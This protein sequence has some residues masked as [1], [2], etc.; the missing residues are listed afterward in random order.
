MPY[1]VS[2]INKNSYG[3]NPRN[4]YSVGDFLYLIADNDA[5]GTELWQVNQSTGVA[6]VVEVNP[7]SAGSNPNN[8][9]VAGNTL[10]FTASNPTS[11]N[12]LWKIV[13]GGTPTVVDLY[14][15]SGS[16]S[17]TDFV[18][19]VGTIYFIASG[20]NGT[21]FTGREIWRID[22][23][24][25]TATV[26]ELASGSGSISPDNLTNVNG[27]L[28]FTASN[29][30]TTN[31]GVELYK[32]DGNTPVLLKDIYV[33]TNGSS[34]SNL[35]YANGKL[36]FT[37]ENFTEGTELW[38]TDGT[39]A[40][41]KLTSDINTN[42]YSSNPTSFISVGTTL[43]FIANNDVSGYE[44]W[45]ADAAGNVSIVELAAG[46]GGI[47]P[48]SGSANISNLTNVNGTLYFQAY[49]PTDGY[50]LWKIDT[51]GTLSQISLYAG[52]NG[53]YVE[54]G[55]SSPN[56]LIN[57]GG[58]LYFTASGYDGV[59]SS[60]L[61]GNELWRIDPT[62]GNP[63]VITIAAGSGSSSPSNLTSIGGI[64]YFQASTPA[65]GRELWKVNPDDNLP[66]L[67]S[68]LYAGGNSSNPTAV[69]SAGGNIYFVAN[70]GLNGNELFRITGNTAPE[71]LDIRT[72]PAIAA[73]SSPTG[74]IDVGGILYFLADNGTNGQELWKANSTGAPIP[75]EI[76]TGASGANVNYLTNVG[77][78][79]YFSAS[80]DNNGYE[81][82]KIGTDGNPARIDIGT[83]GS[84]PDNLTNVNGTLYFRSTEAYDGTTFV[85]Y[86][87]L[88][89]IDSTGI[90]TLIQV[91]S[92]ATYPYV[93]NITLVGSKLFFSAND[94]TNGYELWKV[95]STGGAELVKDIR[96]GSNSSSPGN[97]FAIGE[98]LYFTAN[99]GVSGNELWKSDGTAT[100][101]VLAKDI[102]GRT[103]PSNPTSFIT[104]GNTLYFLADNGIDGQELW[105]VDPSTGLPVQLEINIGNESALGGGEG[106][107]GFGASAQLE[108][109]GDNQPSYINYLT[110]VN[111]TLYFSA[112]DGTNGTELWK[113][114]TDGNPTR[115]DIGTNG[116]SPDNLT[117]V[118]GTLYFRSNEAYSGTNF[119]GYGQLWKIDSTTGTP[120]LIQVGSDANYPYV[121][122][123]TLVGS[124]LFFSAN[125]GTNGYELWKVGSTGAE[126]VK[127][128]RTG[129]NSSSPANFFDVNGTLYFTANDGVKG[130]E[131]WKSDGTAA[132]TVLAKD[133]N[134]RTLP[135][136][137]TNLINVGNTLYFLAD[138]GIDGRELWKVDPTTGLPVQL[139]I[140]SGANG[141]NVN[142]LT[143]VNGTLYFSAND[144]NNGTELWK[145]GT[146][147][148]PARIDIGNG[149]SS[150]DNL[151]NVNG[152]LYFRSTEA[153]SGTDFVGYGQLWK[154]DSTTGA[155]SII[156]VGSEVTYP[157][158]DNIT[159]VGS[160][161]Y[162]SANDGTNGNELWKVNSTGAELVKDIR[163]GS[164]SSSPDNFFDVNGTLYFTANDGVNGNELWKSD[165]TATGTVMLEI[166]TGSTGTSI[167]NM[168]SVAG[169]LYFTAQN[170][171]NGQE[172]W[173]INAAGN[174]E[175][176]DNINVGTGSSSPSNL[177]NVNGTLYF[178]AYNP[179][180]GFELWKVVG[181]SGTPTLIN[182]YNGGGSSSPSN[183]LNING[184]LYFTASG[185]NGTTSTG[186]ELWKIDPNGTLSTIEIVAGGTGG[187]PTNLTN[188]NGNLYFTAYYNGTI[189]TGLELYRL[190]PVTGTPV[191]LKDIYVGS[192]G[193]DPGSL[194]YSNGKLYFSAD[195]FTEGREL[196]AYDIISITT[197]GNV[198]KTG[199]EDQSIAFAASDFASVFNSSNGGT[200]ASIRVVALPSNGTL[201]LNNVNVAANQEILAANLGSL[202]F[203][204]NANFNGNA[205]FTWNGSD[206]TTYATSPATVSM[207][208]AAVNDAPELV[209]A[210]PNVNLTAN[211]IANFSISG[212][213]FRDVDLDNL[214]Y[215]ATLAD[216]SALPS[217][218]TFNGTSF[219][220]TPPI[221]SIGQNIEVKVTATDASSATAT[222]NFFLNILS[223]APNYI[224]VGNSGSGT[225]AENSANDAQV[226]V[227]T[228]A[229]PSTND[230]FTY[231]LLN[232][233]GGRFKVDG[234]RLLV[235]DTSLLDYETNTSHTI[236]VRT[237]DGTGLTYERDIT[238]F[239]SNVNDAN[240]G[241]L[242]FTAPT[243][244][245][246]ENGTTV[247]AVTVQ[248]TNG[249]EGFVRANIVLTN[250]T[251]TYPTD[252]SVVS[253]PVDFA[254][255]ETSKTVTIPIV[256]DTLT[257]M[258]ET[259]NLTL[260]SP[261]GGAT[262]GT[263]TTAVL[264]VV[265]D[266]EFVAGIL[267]FASNSYTVNENGTP[268]VTILRT[269]G[270]NGT[271]SVNILPTDGTA[272]APGDYTTTPISVSFA[273][274]ETSKTVALTGLINDD[275]S[276]EQTENLTLTLST[277]MG[278]A[279]LGTQQTAT[280]N[281][282]DN[283]A[284]PGVVQFSSAT[285]SVDEAGTPV[286][287]ITLNRTGGS[288][289]AV[290]VRVDL[291]NGT[292]TSSDYNSNPITVSFAN[293]ETSKT[294]TIPIVNDTL[295]E[296]D[297]TVTLTLT[298]PQGGAT[299]GTQTTSVLTI[300]ANDP[301][302]PGTLAFASNS[303]S[304]NENGIP[305]VTV[306]RTGGSSGMV[307]VNIVP[308]DGTA[309]TP[310]DYNSTPISVSFAD[311]EI[312]KTVD[313]TGLVTDDALYELAENLTLTLATPMG[314][315][316][317]GTQQTAT[318]NIV[319][320]DAVPGVIQLSSATYS[321]N[322]DGTP[323]T[324]IIT[325]NRTGGSDG[326]VS[327]R[328]DLSNGTA[329]SSDY[330][331]SPI[332]VNF[333]NGE[334]S[335]TVTIPITND[336]AIESTET[337]NLTLTNPTGG[338]AIDP[339]KN[340]A[341]VSIIDDD[342]QIGFGGASY[343]VNE[344]GT[345]I[346][347][348]TVTRSGRTTGSVSATLSFTDGTAKGCVC[349][350]SSV[351]NDFFNGTFAINFADGET[352]KVIPVQLA[353]LG[354][355]NALRI[356]DDARVEGDEYFSINL[357]SPTG[358]ATIGSQ[359][360]ATVT[361]VDN[362]T[363]PVLSV[364]FDRNSI[365]ENAGT[366][367]AT[368]TVTRSMAT[369][370]PLVVSLSSDDPTEATVPQ[371]VTIAAGQ[372][373]T[374]FSI[375]AI[376]DLLLDGT[377][378]VTIAATPINPGTTDPLLAGKGTGSIQVTD[379]E[380]PGLFLKIDRQTIAETG[381]AIATIT[382]NTDPTSD[383]VVNL[384]SNDPTE[385]TVPQQVT[386]LAG[387]ATAT[388][389]I[390]GVNDGIND[391]PQSVI[392][393][394][395]APGLTAVTE[396]LKVTDSNVANLTIT[397]LSGT[398]PTYTTKQSQF[399]YTV[400]NS[401]ITTATGTWK[402]RVYL[403]TDNKLDSSDL[404]LNE[405]SLGTATT[406]AQLLPNAA[407]TQTVSYVAPR[408]AGQYYLIATTDVG[409]TIDEG[410]T[411][412]EGDNTSISAVK[413]TPAYR[414]AVSTDT[415][416]AVVGT[417]VIMRGQALSNIDNS[418]VA[419][420]FVKIQIE[421]KGSTREV[422]AFTDGSGNFVAKFNPLPNEAG[423]Y[424]IK[425]YFPGNVGEDL[426]AEDQFALLGMR[427]EQNDQSLSTVSQKIV[428]GK[429]FSGSVKLQNLADL[430]LSGLTA[431]VV[432]APSNWTVTVTPEKSGLAGNEEI[433][434]NYQITVPDRS[435]LGDVFQLQLQTQEGVVAT[436]PV[437]VNVELILPRLVAD[438]STIQSSMLRGGQNVVEFTVTNQGGAASGKL[439]VVLPDAPWLKLASPVAIPSLAPGESTKVSLL[440][441]AAPDLPLSVYN[442]NLAIN[443][444]ESSLS[445]PF[446]FRSISEA[447]G[448]LKL[449]VV[450]E[451]TFFGD[452]ANVANANIT[453]V[454]AL[455]GTV[456]F[457]G[458][459]ADGLISLTDLNEGYYTLN[460]SADSHDT[461]QQNV[462]VSAGKTESVEAFLSR[463]TVKYTWIV[464]PTEIKDK[465]TISVQ[466][467]FETDVPIPVVT[468][469]PPLIDLANL[470]VIGQV[471]QVDMVVTNHGLIKANDIKLNFGE[472]PFYKIEPLVNN[473]DG[474]AA[475]SSLTVPVRITRIADLNTIGTTSI[476]TTSGELITQAPPS[477]PCSLSGSIGWSYPCGG[478]DINKGSS[479]GFN[480]VAGNCSGTGPGSLN[481]GVVGILGGGGPVGGGPGGGGSVSSY[482]PII[483][484]FDPCCL[485]L[486]YEKDFSDFFKPFVEKAQ[487]TVNIY[488]AAQTGKLAEVKLKVKAKAR[489]ETCCPFD[490]GY[491]ATAEATGELIVG[492]KINIG[493]GDEKKGEDGKPELD[494]LGN[495][496][497]KGYEVPKEL[498]GDSGFKSIKASG[499]LFVGITATP[500]I[501]ISGTV[502]KKCKENFGFEIS[503]KIGAT[504]AAGI[505]GKI[506]VEAELANGEKPKVAVVDAQG[507]LFG[508][509][510]YTFKYSTAGGFSDCVTS[511]GLYLAAYASAFGAT[512]SAFDNPSTPEVETKKYLLDPIACDTP[513]KTSFLDTASSG[514]KF[515]AESLGLPANVSLESYFQAQ[516]E[517]L[518]GVPSLEEKLKADYAARFGTESLN[519]ALI[520]PQAAT[521]SVCAKVKIQI[522]QSAVMTRSAFL[523]S[524]EIENSNATE[525]TNLSV[526]L[527][528][529][530]SKGNLVNTLF[531]ITPA[532]LNN[533]TAVDGTGMLSGE[534]P[535][536]AAKEGIG[537]A[538]WTFIPT[539]LA[540]PEVPEQYSIG[541]TLSY[542]EN[543]KQVTVPLL[544]T[545]VTVYPQAELY[546]NYFQSRNVYGD[547]PFTIDIEP[548]VP[549]D[550][551]VL[552]EN[553]GKGDAKD[554]QITSAQP[555][556]IENEKGLLI[557]FQII[558]SE[559]NGKGVTPSLEANF[560]DIKAGKTA[561]ADWLLK[562]SLQGKFIDYK[563]TFEHV[564]S[565][566]IAELSLIKDVK[567]HELIRKVQVDK[568]TDDG[569]ADFLVN[570]TLDDKFTPDTLYFSQGG[571][572][573][574]NAASGATADGAAATGDLEV[575]ISA[576]TAAG[577]NYIELADP[578][579]A[580]FDIQKIQRA[581]GSEV[582]L[583]NVWTTD[584]TFPGKGRPTYENILH[585]LDNSSAAG[586]TTYTITYKAAGPTVTDIVDVSPDP[587]A[588]AVS[589]IT[590]EF[591]EAIDSSTLD[592][593][594]LSLSL[595]GGTNLIDSTVAVVAVSPTSYQIT[596]LNS[597]TATDGNYALTVNA[598]GIKDIA[599]KSGA[600]A[601]TESWQKIATGVN[602]ITGPAVL[603]VVNLAT[604]L[605]NQTVS[606]L[607]V[608]FSEA[609]DLS[610]LTSADLSLTLNG[611]ANLITNN[612][613][614][615]SVSDKVYRIGGL[616]AL[617]A[618]EGTYTFTVNG[619]GIKDLAGNSGT[620]SQSESWTMD[621]TAP[622]A[623]SNLLVAGLAH[624]A[625][626]Q[627]I[628]TAAPTISGQ[629]AESGLQVSFYDK[630]ANR[631]LS[632]ATVSDTSFTGAVNLPGAGANEVELQ[633]Q[634]AAG[635]IKKTSLELFA[636]LA[637]P[638]VVKLSNLPETQSYSPVTYVDV[639][640]SEAIKASTFT[641][642]DLVLTRDGQDVTLPNTVSIAAISDTVYRVSG[643][644]NS[645]T[646]IGNY[647]FRV[648]ATGIQDL[649]G[650]SA[651]LPKTANFSIIAL[652]TPGF[653]LT[654]TEGNTS[655][656]EGGTTD[657]YSL[658]LK[659]Q[660]TADVTIDLAV[661]TQLTTDKTTL[662]FTPSNWNTAQTVTVTAVNDT[663]PEVTQTV[664]ITHTVTSTDPN[665]SLQT[666]PNLS[667]NITDNDAEIRGLK[668]NDVNGNGIK[669]TTETGLKDWSI[670]LDT[671]TNGQLDAGEI[672]TTT[673]N[674][675]NYS[676]TNL[677]PG[678]YTVA[679]QLQPG[680]KQT[681]PG[682]S[683]TTTAS[684]I[685]LINPSSPIV[686]S[687]TFSTTSSTNLVSLNKLWT[688]PRFTN[689]KGK[690]YSTVIIDT[691]ADLNSPY[692]GADANNDGIAD[693]IVYQYDF[694]DND[695]DASDKNNHGSHVA[696]IASAVA[697]EANLIILKVFKDSGTGSFSNLEKALQWV[698]ANSE[699]YN[700]ASVNLSLGD[701]QDWN[702][703]LSR[704]GIGDELAAIAEQNVLISAAAGNG[705]YTYN[706]AVGLAYPAIDPSVISVGAVWADN[707][708]ARTFS[709]GAK[710]NTTAP[711]RVASFS[712][713]S[714]LLDVFAPGIL[715]T[716]ANATGGSITMGG[717]SQATPFV[718]GIATLAQQIAQ[719]SLGRKLTLAEFDTLLDTKSDLIIDGDDENDNVANTGATYPRINVL[720]L[721]EGIL[722]LSG[723][724][725]TTTPTTP[726]NG[727]NSTSLN[728]PVTNLNLAHTVTLA[729]GD[730]KTDLNF[731]NQKIERRP[732]N[733][734]NGDR[735]SDI[736]WRNTDGSV[737]IWQMDGSTATPNSIQQ[738]T[739]D[740]TLAGTGDFNGDRKSDILW[741]NTDGNIATWQMD[742]AAV[743]QPST[744]GTATT[745]WTFVGTGDFNGDGSDDLLWRN[746]DGSV[747]TWQ[748]NNSIVTKTSTIGTALADWQVAGTGDFDGDSKADIL[749]QNTN[750]AIAIWQMDGAAVVKASSFAIAP[751]GWKINGTGDFDGDGKTEI[752]WRNTDGGDVAT[753]Q[754]DGSKITTTTVV[755]KTTP[756]WQ[757]A[758][759]G[760]FNGDGKDDLLWRNT[761][762]GV[763]T[764]QVNG[765]N[766]I[767]AGSTSISTADLAWKIAAPIL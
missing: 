280:L 48:G 256:N 300:L 442:G 259:L 364:T 401:G 618:A 622:L 342:V 517:K 479:I 9:I 681:Y 315:A 720:S 157:Y 515:F 470:E 207:S 266:D 115:I 621:T 440:L 141:S 671:N 654:Q 310:S 213:A 249:S 230:T 333:A 311:G 77:G 35:T 73:S 139:E 64:L 423:T 231:T 161:L 290:S 376:D 614:I 351:N 521:D 51:S 325:L 544:S 680:W 499:N 410:L 478:R 127:D 411:G 212:N 96:T 149:G 686:T 304:V 72:N 89:K 726:T 404:L 584:R 253:I 514:T 31:T 97:F 564:N 336:T 247:A 631:L 328:V 475:N 469:D 439:D 763:A 696:S 589:A 105:K 81:L 25:G 79:L 749:F 362:D 78:T 638:T 688:D 337:L 120:T 173:R 642:D 455:T 347:E 454:D 273:N 606:G 101:T 69:V 495:K 565:L 4:F 258:S 537:S 687:D 689:I 309:V 178:Q 424:K 267:A 645:T 572:A 303:Y 449:D 171:A 535:A 396:T 504:F 36:Y 251:A 282:V 1:L 312:S 208:I 484:K 332:T 17:P 697:P 156:Q 180:N 456:V 506:E 335:K 421:N 416:T 350:S 746:T 221:A 278:G 33:G 384:N 37:A 489:V 58:T 727:G 34:P 465:Y 205:A 447:K 379:N 557:D 365:S 272:I 179:A 117:N 114:G 317:L 296:P 150:P 549:F 575:Q 585:I 23:A 430:P 482:T 321:V 672:S 46:N 41:T 559:V 599:G 92:G 2:D 345:A 88:W 84:S 159:L 269:G 736:L 380:T 722:S 647:A 65:T 38:E 324:A 554:L 529:K 513:S 580:Q 737:A 214:T 55:S 576:T 600:G 191:F 15:N 108:I 356:R 693:K 399:V 602:D 759:T 129:S 246:N 378:A 28:Y 673:D 85:G 432:D 704:Y 176:L 477:V 701:G 322:E 305:S 109:S 244:S 99:D 66:V 426:N 163:T 556:I 257:E 408:T 548:S 677:R 291:S 650:N 112:N 721:A 458:T 531:G 719:T 284:V 400:T 725:P 165:G 82:W 467:T 283:D 26:I 271:V 433:T 277:P 262:L 616:T 678:T 334:T 71:L 731:G 67:V 597:L 567:I 703:P 185:F 483:T 140:Y 389:T 216:N 220:G 318:L 695:T 623:N 200:L 160:T 438:T 639:E 339:T 742:G 553:K 20:Y 202:T 558:G 349:A 344:D 635:N 598:G 359:A 7:G 683:V 633:V 27:I 463:Q 367:A 255:G 596:G 86:G 314:G 450:D 452:G 660:P 103:L 98:T 270:S 406:P 87:Q 632:Q 116:S 5:S 40:G 413:I 45:K 508:D 707:F 663:V 530:D 612:I 435:V 294:V 662:T 352:S 566:G 716:G 252:Y 313:L 550:L 669:D 473:V 403:S 248:R 295:N 43:Y 19:I 679:E 405:F 525:L 395:S 166:N 664:N 480:N 518:L 743:T 712:Q 493:L 591:S 121:D 18:N 498:L 306:T 610:T 44:L 601:L 59:N 711:D 628:N 183:L 579:N 195:N 538:K 765:A 501:S 573:A 393:K 361:I 363:V 68:D 394:A 758:E 407:Y 640:F 641:I 331:S 694:A 330:N 264:T 57:V 676:F 245:I 110:N 123:I 505:T 177:T 651:E 437:T 436:L 80:D 382:R 386:I 237:T 674:S 702:T 510:F 21:T 152:T 8:L 286:T 172:L 302:L 285:Y 368:G 199:T 563:A 653:T 620:G 11:G 341:V 162:F 541:G 90:P 49:N 615:S 524:L 540:A 608:V 472:H 63:V 637:G 201:K 6:N 747:A 146:D 276:N 659:T 288:D 189:N 381:T 174:P 354:G 682:V 705:F 136:N 75:L 684:D 646:A 750:G 104:V 732:K 624:G 516:A 32:L 464:Q 175:V 391:G 206:G 733:D 713:R 194:T 209:N 422:D 714:P 293:G 692:F 532:I 761:N 260:T 42:T 170:T 578:S 739:S 320:N 181:A 735:K 609:I 3:S 571:T 526:N 588:T 415:D 100:G 211:N 242:S 370:T 491:Y 142:Y 581:D 377:Q 299:L 233:A 699:A 685:Q 83:G 690:G 239:V 657:T 574:V 218:L 168:V 133:I 292:A 74:L 644:G 301:L 569:L 39:T 371:Q 383:L 466:S 250:G 634:D 158:V 755:G 155:P 398:Q 203:V 193:S 496:K 494:P 366:V 229:D 766:V 126:L 106:E 198:P 323:V 137:P 215:S 358:G 94:G 738:L 30:G 70:N 658:V 145:I 228:S 560:G 656:T 427:F 545:P 16:S 764:W 225:I 254:N 374:T 443:G 698:N 448:D 520:S 14:L 468:I 124:T 740:W 52:K 93:D 134:G 326:A 241:T 462:Y 670:Y 417:P 594:D 542:I 691:G 13:N 500:T 551:G 62:T 56:N 643:L 617:T 147:G 543:G 490:I 562:S 298:N 348:I 706:S 626:Q 122:N 652:P 708:G 748:M 429:T 648:N 587:R 102:N 741:R 188:V 760:D 95:N 459:D 338:A 486:A 582:S 546:L 502:G 119:V 219:S 29:N 130:L 143:N 204:P 111:G 235:A 265:D 236:R 287:A 10:Y 619:A 234:D 346:S 412:G 340:T 630:V 613:T 387:Q 445:L 710:D 568:P 390:A 118:N 595:N 552:I 561:V 402:D 113:I 709:N 263:Q 453:L 243:Y 476:F 227:L 471:M 355:T 753:W 388:F 329:T 385:A 131:L 593:Q 307:T 503:G 24:T 373:S 488:L 375:D 279:T 434:V 625:G 528:V 751:A 54:A 667:V 372:T 724:S 675:G 668:W 47:N 169:T 297:E 487:D 186:S 187:S 492:P 451:L 138:N 756:D 60:T 457:S 717:T 611:G 665:Y 555:K 718:S 224:Y 636:D 428:E 153:Y 744:I 752:L 519:A 460:V 22:P 481:L 238:I 397:N 425:A 190:D 547:D 527:E 343:S 461:F 485:N 360:S 217:W 357:I 392:I 144:A 197:V 577:W 590:V 281:I 261:Q 536:T 509:I 441:Q 327:V 666:I 715:I 76:R 274:G 222:D 319:D 289:G 128:I 649:A 196:W 629:L 511:S 353:S 107:G 226:G 275:T 533:I 592:Y 444:V 661:G 700:I 154:I 474:L 728:L 729:A 512:I 762:G 523:G 184:T 607:N 603:D 12:E 754:L 534:N 151:T 148:N 369:A 223:S 734:F 192:T 757:I 627:R 418:P 164:G 268:Q 431:S 125:D 745:A 135:S 497:Y 723:N 53:L 446:S 316:T 414:A 522:D 50:E 409:N 420:E 570:D 210:I 61:T 605:R 583:K 730:V 586:N 91:G 308:S 507:G 132:G 240:A 167:A 767:A 419:Y 232:N 655:V 604:N 182:L 539:N